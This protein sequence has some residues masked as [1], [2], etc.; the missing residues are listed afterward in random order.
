MFIL[1]QD[2]DELYYIQKPY[3]IEGKIAS[4]KNQYLGIN[5]YIDN[6]FLG[7]FDSIE[8]YLQEEYN[9]KHCN[10]ILYKINGFCL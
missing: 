7:T 5:L 8:E 2:R 9:I 4:Y 6:V 1:N 3:K 10:N